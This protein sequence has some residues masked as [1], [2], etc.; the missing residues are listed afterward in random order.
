MG[1]R[2]LLARAFLLVFSVGVVV[3]PAA[4]AGAAATATAQSAA[5]SH[6]SLLQDAA[7]I[8]QTAG[9][10]GAIATNPDQRLV[11][12]YLANFAAMG[13]ARAAA[14]GDRR[15]ANTAWRWLAWYQA[16]ED[17]HGYVDDYARVGLVL[18]SKGTM[19]STDAY[20]GTYLLAVESVFQATADRT[21]LIS[22]RPGI[23]GAIRAIESTQ[24]V[25]GLTW[26]KPSW[27]VKYLM[28]Q[29]ETYAGLV[30]AENIGAA[31]HAPN[32]VQRTAR[33]ARRMHAGFA[34]LWNPSVG[35]YDWA[36]HGNGAH[37]VTNWNVLYPDAMQQVWAVAF[38]LADGARAPQLLATLNRR[39]P[40]WASPTATADIN[41]ANAQVGYWAAATWAL[42]RVGLSA[43]GPVRSI[44][45]AALSAHRGVALHFGSGRPADGGRSR[46]ARPQAQGGGVA[47]SGGTDEGESRRDRAGRRDELRFPG[48]PLTG[49]Q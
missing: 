16:H 17:A 43:T 20:A 27:H 23:E 30:A 22:L 9:A 3:A 14:V 5:R 36:V 47:Q 11:W 4:G 24:D 35:A 2:T 1:R 25:D 42:R 18:R 13:L 6:A 26:A 46:A 19:D 37:A 33:D 39:Q 32:L 45:D 41:S 12:P 8:E 48:A 28:D 38:G 31:L 15:A 7:W 21:Q 40:E 10:D 34:K 49:E 44:R 29:A